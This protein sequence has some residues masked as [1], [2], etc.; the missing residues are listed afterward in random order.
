MRKKLS[1]C[2]IPSTIFDNDAL[3]KNDPMYVARLAALPEAEKKAF[4][5]GD[6]NTFSGQVFSEWKDDP[7]HY[8]DRIGTHVINPFEI[9]STWGVWCGMDWGYSRPYAIGWF[10]VDPDGRIYHIRE[11]YG[12]TGTPNQ[13]VHEEPAVVSDR[14]AEIEEND[15]NLKDKRIQRVGD[16]AIWGTQGT[17]SI[18]DIFDRRRQYFNKGNNSR[19]DGKM[20]LHHRLAMDENGIPMMYVFSTCKNFIR[21][22]PSLVYDEK[23]VEDIDTRQEDHAYDMCR[24]VLMDNPMAPP[25]YKERQYM[26]PTPFD[27]DVHYDNYSY[28]AHY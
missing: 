13:G 14:I 22:L 10:A 19:I 9:P 15:P 17:Q 1:R 21:T 4:L 26:P 11:L 7:D 27:T 23:K 8:A 6:W 16:P 28:F 12:C 25:I 2:F 5:Y 24:Y 20:Q 3:M 18:G